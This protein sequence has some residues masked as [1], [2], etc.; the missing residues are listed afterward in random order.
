MNEAAKQLCLRIA[1]QLQGLAEIRRLAQGYEGVLRVHGDRR[2]A[3]VTQGQSATPSDTISLGLAVEAACKVLGIANLQL[4]D[5]PFESLNSFER[6]V[7]RRCAFMTALAPVALPRELSCSELLEV[8]LQE[9][10]RTTADSQF[11]RAE[12]VSEDGVRLAVFEAGTRGNPPLVLVIPAGMPVDIAAGWFH[13]L[14][15]HYHVIT[16]EQRGILEHS[17]AFDDCDHSFDV[18][19]R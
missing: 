19:V 1:E 13:A 4:S 14:G 2:R 10:H 6:I 18:H 9:L 12:I 17:V 16:W 15:E 3:F 7:S 8:A 11:K 5:D